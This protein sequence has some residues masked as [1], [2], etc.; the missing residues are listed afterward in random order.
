MS[1]RPLAWKGMAQQEFRNTLGTVQESLYSSALSAFW[2]LLCG[3]CDVFCFRKV[4]ALSRGKMHTYA[5][6]FHKP[7]FCPVPLGGPYYDTG[8]KWIISI[9]NC[10]IL[11]ITDI[12]LFSPF[13]AKQRARAEQQKKACSHWTIAF[14]NFF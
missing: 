7:D 1:F 4:L 14:P 9:Q 5:Y 10:S 3:E 6:V 13:K 12:F 8:E 11:I 2:W